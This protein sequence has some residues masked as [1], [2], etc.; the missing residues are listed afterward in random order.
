MSAPDTTQAAS[1][2]PA[3]CDAVA[4]AV[5]SDAAAPAANAAAASVTPAAKPA[6]SLALKPKVTPKKAVE[7]A[8]PVDDGKP[9]VMALKAGPVKKEAKSNASNIAL[10]NKKALELHEEEAVVVPTNAAM[11][12]SGQTKRSQV[13]SL[14]CGFLFHFSDCFL[15]FHFPLGSERVVMSAKGE[16]AASAA[17]LIKETDVGAAQPETEKSV[18]LPAGLQFVCFPCKRGFYSDEQM[19]AHEQKSLNHRAILE[20]VN[21]Q[22]IKEEITSKASKA[23]MRDEVKKYRQ[24][25]E[26][27]RVVREDKIARAV[28]PADTLGSDNV[29]NKLLQKMGWS[30]GK[31]MTCFGL[32]FVLAQPR[33][34]LGKE[35][36]GSKAP[37]NVVM[38]EER[39]GL[40]SG[41]VCC[42]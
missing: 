27:Q 25:L 6:F 19:L 17:D 15:Q 37:I 35:E 16:S 31:G 40:G 26:E 20:R 39:A 30:E 23:A 24:A 34:G 21:I 7:A 38:R 5:A 36:T 8:P 9:F 1:A 32:V 4:E 3:A 22:Q 42:H 41:T 18:E 10:W 28:G 33:A 2:A 14:S 13:P 12:K 29:G 11:P